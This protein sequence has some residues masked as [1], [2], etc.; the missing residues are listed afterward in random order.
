MAYPV[1]SPISRFSAPAAR[2]IVCVARRRL[3]PPP[4]RQQRHHHRVEHGSESVAR[5][6][7]EALSNVLGDGAMWMGWP[8]GS[9]QP[10]DVRATHHRVKYSAPLFVQSGGAQ[11]L[12]QRGLTG[13]VSA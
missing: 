6:A 4:A 3:V 11:A 2:Q 1:L 13:G 9:D 10:T 5:E 12:G 8:L 7:R